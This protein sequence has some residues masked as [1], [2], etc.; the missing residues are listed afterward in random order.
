MIKLNPYI[1]STM[2]PLELISSNQLLGNVGFG[3][4]LPNHAIENFI[5]NRIRGLF[6]SCVYFLNLVFFCIIILIL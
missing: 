3:V 6:A 5:E 2:G 1:C 4:D